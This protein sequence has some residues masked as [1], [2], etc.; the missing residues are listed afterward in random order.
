MKT[1]LTISPS[2][3]GLNDSISNNSKLHKR[4]TARAVLL[5]SNDEVYLLNVS[6]HGYHKLPGGGINEGESITQGL[7]RELLEEVGCRA[8]II[9]EVGAVVE[10]HNLNSNVLE[11]TSYCYLARQA[12][13]QTVS[14]LEKEELEEG[15]HEFKVGS[16][17][18][19]IKLLENDKPDNVQ[20]R[21]IQKRELAFLKKA[22]ELM[23]D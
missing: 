19:A 7:E 18:D 16:I 2:D 11:Q 1:I 6:K 14:S 17:N 9:N 13:E 12:G 8:E 21:Y 3:F 15:I 4:R 20:G 23:V 10:H 5:T 22:R